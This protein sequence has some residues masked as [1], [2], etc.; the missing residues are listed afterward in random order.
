MIS[1]QQ[2]LKQFNEEFSNLKEAEKTM[3][4]LIVNKLFK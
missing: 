2:A 3:F 1:K 4:S